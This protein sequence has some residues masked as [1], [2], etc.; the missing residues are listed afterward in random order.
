MRS[1]L[2]EKADSMHYWSVGR[3]S[4]RPTLRQLCHDI[5]RN[6]LAYAFVLPSMAG[7]FAVILVPLVQTVAVSF[8]RYY[9]LDI[10][11]EAPPFVGFA[12]YLTILGDPQFRFSLWLTVIFTFACV[13]LT[14]LVGLFVAILLDQDF[15]G[16]GIVA[17]AVLVPW[18]IPRIASSIL[19]KWIYDDQ[20]GILNHMLSSI[21][22]RS[23]ASFPWLA[24]AGPAFWA[25]VVVVVWQ[26]FPFIAVTLL[27]G[28]R[29]I[30][31]EVY[32]A[33]EIDGAGFWQKVVLISIPMLRNLLAILIVISTIW[34]F[35]VFDQM[36]V[37]TEGGP[38]GSTMIL[39]IYTWMMAFGRLQMGLASALAMIM[40]MLVMAVTVLYLRL[41]MREETT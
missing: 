27:A 35:K 26:S 18:V 2:A 9:I 10:L 38:A 33:A 32:E 17:V 23:L 37:L 5:T 16:R 24:R 39:G 15:P 14:M 40:F 13:A 21:G 41:F 19:W 11:R 1:P 30:P 7:V 25:V 31:R 28:L 20:F 12:N 3:G 6:W 22:L 34:D 36:Y 29:T 4:P 8:K